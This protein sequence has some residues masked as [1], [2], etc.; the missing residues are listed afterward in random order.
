MPDAPL[1][2]EKIDPYA[3]VTGAT[4]PASELT[5]HERTAIQMEYVVPLIRDLQAILGEDVVNAALEERLRRQAGQAEDAPPVEPDMARMGEAT[6]M[7]AAGDALEYEMVGADDEH[8]DMNVHRCAYAEMMERLGAR[9]VGHLL[10][11][12]LDFAEA[13]R[14]GL[15]LTRTQTLMQGATFCDFR[16]RKRR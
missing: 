12:N 6:K 1:D 16:Y 10:L 14:A 7:F 9:D 2:P 8:F 15:D 4:I 5:F 13:T 3:L 11:C